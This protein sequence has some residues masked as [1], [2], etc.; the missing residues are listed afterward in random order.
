MNVSEIKAEIERLN[1]AQRAALRKRF[2]GAGIAYLR[3]REFL[4]RIDGLHIIFKDGVGYDVCIG[5]RGSLRG[6]TCLGR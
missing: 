3:C 6:V 2:F 5:P 4:G 1:P